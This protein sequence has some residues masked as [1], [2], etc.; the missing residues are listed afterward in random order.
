MLSECSVSIS[1]YAQH[2]TLRKDP[3]APLSPRRQHPH[4][5]PDA[6]PFPTLQPNPIIPTNRKNHAVPPH[7]PPNIPPLN[8]TPLPFNHFPHLIPPEHPT[9]PIHSLK[10]EPHPLRR[11]PRP[12]IVRVRLPHHAPQPNPSPD[13]RVEQVSQQQ[14]DGVR[15]DVAALERRQDGDVPDLRGRE[16]RRRVQ[17]AHHA[18]QAARRDGGGGTCG[19]SGIVSGV[20]VGVC[21]HDDGWCE[22]RLRD[23]GVEE[24]GVV[25]HEARFPQL[26]AE[27]GDVLARPVGH[28]AEELGVRGRGVEEGL[29]V[30]FGLCV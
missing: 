2:R 24:A 19:R 4:L 6:L 10:P 27:V 28:V 7:H 26:R 23:D 22:R 25:L 16:V 17:Q 14:A 3:P 11:I 13:R 20:G 9:P 15:A 21:T 29:G 8:P 30:D 18:R 12:H 1:I 5:L